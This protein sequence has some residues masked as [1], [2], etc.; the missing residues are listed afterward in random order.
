MQSEV[1]CFSFQT[2]FASR[3]KDCTSRLGSVGW[4]G[5]RHRVFLIIRDMSGPT[6]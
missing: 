4:E 2:A 1:L 3:D 6:V 5:V